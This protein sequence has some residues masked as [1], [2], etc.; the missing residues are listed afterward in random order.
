MSLKLENFAHEL[1]RAKLFITH[2]SYA[3]QLIFVCV[4]VCVCAIRVPKCVRL[5]NNS[6]EKLFA[7]SSSGSSN[8][9]NF[10]KKNISIRKI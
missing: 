7:D 10:T 4:C 9:E 3:Y 6:S 8:R 1:V 5:T 2:K